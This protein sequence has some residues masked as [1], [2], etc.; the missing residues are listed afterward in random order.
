MVYKNLEEKSSDQLISII[1]DQQKKIKAVDLELTEFRTNA[2]SFLEAALDI[3]FLLDKDGNIIYR[4]PASEI[5]IT[6]EIESIKGSHYLNYFTKNLRQEAIK[7]FASVLKEGKEIKNVETTLKD[8]EGNL[9][10]LLANLTPVK[11]I[12]G[13][14]VGLLAIFRDISEKVILMEKLRDNLARLEEKIKDGHDKDK[15]LKRALTLNEEIINTAPVGVFMTDSSGIMLS[16]NPALKKIMKTPENRSL[17]G[18]NLYEYKNFKEAGLDKYFDKVLETKLPEKIDRV[19]YKTN[20]NGD[21]VI[22]NVIINPILSSQ[23]KVRNLLFIV[24]DI[25]EQAI[26][27]GRIKRTEKISAMNLMAAGIAEELKMPLSHI[28]IDLNFLDNNLDESSHMKS[29]IN[30]MKE[31]LSRIQFISDQLMDLS[32]TGP[33]SYRHMEAVDMAGIIDSQPIKVKL[34]RMKARGITID[35]DRPAKSPFIYANANQIIQVLI[36]LIANAGEAMPEKGTLSITINSISEREKSFA[37][38][39]VEDTGFGITEENL[40]RIF[41]PFFTTKGAKGSGLGLMVA[42]SVIENI[43]GAIGIKSTPGEGTVVKILI[44]SYPDKDSIPKSLTTKDIDIIHTDTKINSSVAEMILTGENYYVYSQ[45]ESKPETTGKPPSSGYDPVIISR[46][47]LRSTEGIQAEPQKAAAYGAESPSDKKDYHRTLA[48]EAQIDNYEVATIIDH[49]KWHTER[50]SK[51]VIGRDEIIKQIIYAILCREHLLLLSR[52]G[53][54]K[55]Y[56]ANHVFN[57]FNDV[58]VFSTQASKD[59]TPDNYFGPYNIEEFKKG[60]I[61]HN[62]HGSIIEANFVL[63]DEFFDANDVVLRSLLTVLNERKFINGPE[64]IDVAI[65][66]AIATANYMRLNE[67]TEAILDRFL[68]KSIIPEDTDMY[69]QLLIDH[70]YTIN[71]GKVS[72][73][74]RRLSFDQVD[75]ISDIIRNN[76]P[77]IKVQIPDTVYFMKNVLINKFVSEMRKSDINYFVSPRK[78]AKTTDFLRASVLMDGRFEAA[79]DDLKSMYYVLTT[80]N[81]IVTIKQTDKSERDVFLD[82]FE[83]IMI[84][85]KRTGAFDQIEYLLNVRNILQSVKDNPEKRNNLHENRGLFKGMKELLRKLFPNKIEKEDELSI[86]SLKKSITELNPAAEELRE[87]KQGILVDYKE[88]N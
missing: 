6:A 36:H 88:L 22:I 46:A 72:P 76:N 4:N 18:F 38:I 47:A 2:F 43:G 67:V 82:V 71:K 28:N 49:I 32:R 68:F 25:T 73:P 58:R 62:I 65:H 59:Q 19:R 69:N 57:I 9:I 29:Y 20:T 8:A 86:E 35:I 87:L 34:E 24:E 11:A 78:Q 77:D 1:N 61:R 3:I 53:M 70:T 81:N 50:I 85:Y 16:E 13:K 64:Q 80:L 39:E 51:T 42:G 48:S 83:H 75:F 52:T 12:D 56:L 15:D 74:L 44:P 41:Q 14:T 79:M 54:A 30:A 37:A 40:R 21:I 7:Y 84:Q 63:L 31:D 60:R 66:T 5:M 26:L 27:D 23:K 55:S 17:V 33:A 10:Y 45:E